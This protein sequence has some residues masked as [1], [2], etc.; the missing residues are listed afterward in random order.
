MIFVIIRLGLVGINIKIITF[1]AQPT[2]NTK[3][4]STTKVQ[5]KNNNKIS[6]H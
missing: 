1:S 2:Y 4:P 5:S 6:H 3:N